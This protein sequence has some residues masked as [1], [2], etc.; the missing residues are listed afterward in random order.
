MPLVKYF[1]GH[2][3]VGAPECPAGGQAGTNSIDVKNGLCQLAS[4]GGK[5]T[6][7]QLQG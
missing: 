7:V 2:A 5:R 3:P 6:F 1:D 4:L